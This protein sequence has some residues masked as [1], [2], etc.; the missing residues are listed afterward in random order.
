MFS[1][2][3]TQE[4]DPVFRFLTSP[5]SDLLPSVTIMAP[6]MQRKAETNATGEGL[7]EP[8]RQVTPNPFPAHP[9]IQLLDFPP[10][11]F[12][13]IC[14]YLFVSGHM[15]ILQ[16]PSTMY[17]AAS[18]NVHSEGVLRIA[19]PR[20]PHRYLDDKRIASIQKPQGRSHQPQELTSS[21][22]NRP[23]HRFELRSD[24]SKYVLLLV[25]RR[26]QDD[27]QPPTRRSAQKTSQC[28]IACTR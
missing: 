16:T 5:T 10:E 20:C 23:T 22:G 7:K 15:N 9:P 8:Y 4:H 3:G 17:A 14:S 13:K 24:G 2:N 18:P 25:E 26:L 21:I 1:L 6:I 19:H 11:I 27:L 28:Y 12:D